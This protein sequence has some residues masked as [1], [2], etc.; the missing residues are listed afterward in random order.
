MTID[1][2]NAVNK[3]LNTMPVMDDEMHEITM[4]GVAIDSEKQRLKKH[5]EKYAMT[6][7]EI[8]RLEGIEE[9]LIDA[10]KARR[11]AK[12]TCGVIFALCVVCFIARML[13]F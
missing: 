4:Q 7:D 11:K 13:A 10:K 2:K 12:I 6:E 3:D 1:I 8:M 5:N 9:E